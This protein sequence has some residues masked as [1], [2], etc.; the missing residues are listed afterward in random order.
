M[1]DR[2]QDDRDRVWL[3]LEQL[4]G[5]DDSPRGRLIAQLLLRLASEGEPIARERGRSGS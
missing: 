2:H 1:V 5:F 3:L 4:P